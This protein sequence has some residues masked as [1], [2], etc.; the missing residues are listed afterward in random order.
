MLPVSPYGAIYLEHRPFGRGHLPLTHRLTFSEGEPMA[1]CLENAEGLEAVLWPG[2]QLEVE[3]SPCPAAAGQPL[4]SRQDGVNFALW[5]NCLLLEEEGHSVQCILPDGALLPRLFRM[6]GV[7]CLCGPL[8]GGGEYAQVYSADFDRLL[9]SLRGNKVRI[10]EGLLEVL[11]DPQDL[12]GHARLEV[13]QIGEGGCALARSEPMWIGGAP[14]WPQNPRDTAAAALQ[15]AQQGL[16]DEARGYLMPLSECEEALAL[17]RES[18][19]CV[20]LPRP[21]ASGE[22]CVGLMQLVNDHYLR[23]EPIAFRASASAGSQGPWRL[24]EMRREA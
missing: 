13:W 3:L 20:P 9:V 4:V 19:G 7:C 24:N 18:R 16:M 21:T 10:E 11:V 8:T 15:A 17:A 2:R 23:V 12:V 6:E 14:S 1:G 22:S 5:G